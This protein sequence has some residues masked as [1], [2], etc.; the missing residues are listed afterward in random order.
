[1]NL[2]RIYTEYGEEEQISF[3]EENRLELFGRLNRSQAISLLQLPRDDR[4]EFVRTHDM[5]EMSVRDL[6][7][8]IAKI[9]AENEKLIDKALSAEKAR[10]EAEQERDENKKKSEMA[11]A[12][13][14]VKIKSLKDK[15]KTAEARLTDEIEKNKHLSE[16]LAIPAE[17]TPEERQ[18]IADEATSEKE[19]EIENLRDKIS[20]LTASL[21]PTVQRFSVHFESM[22]DSFN[23][24]M[25][26]IHNCGSMET[27]DRLKHAMTKTINILKQTI[28]SE[29]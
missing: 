19:R 29:D 8:E 25:E 23:K 5:S 22:Q 14:R 17:I 9:K 26:L 11:L 10:I 6:D 13:S 15:N 7:D 4:A 21:D 24:M 2:M 20:Q 1:N 28:E 3:F 12:E 27:A 18:K 16:Q